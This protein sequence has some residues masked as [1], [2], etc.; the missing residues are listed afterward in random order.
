MVELPD[1]IET[2]KEKRRQLA[3]H[4]GEA[5]RLENE[6]REIGAVA[7]GKPVHSAG[8]GKRR[9]RPGGADRPSEIKPGSS[10]HWAKR[11]FLWAGRDLTVDEIIEAIRHM[12]GPDVAKPTLV[13]N[14]S[15]YANRGDVFV[16]TGRNKYGLVKEA[17]RVET[18]TGL[19]PKD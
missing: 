4:Q 12:D 1:I 15:R 6:L 16:R 11:A 18:A 10:V 19:V 2:I 13:S 5:A 7:E 17:E 9:S 3:F 8:R 14:L